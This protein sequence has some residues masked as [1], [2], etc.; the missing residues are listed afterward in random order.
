MPPAFRERI[1]NSGTGA[2]L[3]D[4][5]INSGASVKRGTVKQKNENPSPAI[6]V[7]PTRES[8]DQAVRV[9]IAYAHKDLDW[10]NE[11]GLNNKPFHPLILKHGKPW[12][13]GER[14]FA[15]R[16]AKRKQ[17][18]MNSYLLVQNNPSLTY[19]EGWCWSGFFFRLVRRPG[20]AGYRP[21]AAQGRR[22]LRHT[23]SVGLCSRH[24]VEDWVLRR[25]RPHQL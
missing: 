6:L 8:Q 18:Y 14:T 2:K 22:L 1:Q 21:Y 13:I 9:I 12:Y 3:K 7:V 11:F 20:R 19:V 24:R 10:D 5:S 15:G 17:C 25:N 16:R 4:S 23:I